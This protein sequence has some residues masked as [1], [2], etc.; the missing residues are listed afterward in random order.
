MRGWMPGAAAVGLLIGPSAALAAPFCL[1]TLAVP[2]QCMYYD[3]A[4]CS[5]DTGEHDDGV[6]WE[7]GANDRKRFDDG[8]EEDDDVDEARYAVEHM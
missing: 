4:L 2:P 5:K 8:N 1:E 6:T 7:Y 3:V